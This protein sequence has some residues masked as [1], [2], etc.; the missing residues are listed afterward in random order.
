M[1]KNRQIRFPVTINNTVEGTVLGT[2]TERQLVERARLIRNENGDM[3][4]VILT[5]EEAFLYIG[6]YSS[7]LQLVEHDGKSVL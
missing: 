6:T 7:N 3:Q 2:F 1:N 4:E 5:G